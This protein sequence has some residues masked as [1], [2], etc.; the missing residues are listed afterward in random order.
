MGKPIKMSII[1][2]DCPKTNLE[3]EELGDPKDTM[4]SGTSEGSTGKLQFTGIYFRSRFLMVEF[5]GKET[6]N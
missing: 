3:A 4:V 5:V 6:A 2:K 1:D